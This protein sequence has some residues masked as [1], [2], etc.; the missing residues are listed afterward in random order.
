MINSDVEK[1]RIG[2]FFEILEVMSP[3][4][5]DSTLQIAQELDIPIGRATVLRG[6]LTDD[7]V[8]HI[9][10]LHCLVRDGSIAVE[11]AKDAYRIARRKEVTVREAL[12]ALGFDLGMS[13]TAMLGDLLSESDVVDQNAV[14]DAL[15][16]QSLCGMPIG[17]ILYVDSRVPPYIMFLALELQREIRRSRRSVKS[18]VDILR[19][20]AERAKNGQARLNSQKRNGS[21]IEIGEMLVESGVCSESEFS[22]VKGFAKVN[23]LEL[24]DAIRYTGMVRS[25]LMSAASALSGLVRFDY[26][27]EKAARSIFASLSKNSDEHPSRMRDVSLYQFLIMSGFLTAGDLRILTRELVSHPQEVERLAGVSARSLKNRENVRTAIRTCLM[28]GEKLEGLLNSL[29][30]EQR[31]LVA[32]ARDLVSLICL[33]R[34]DLDRAVLSFARMR[35]EVQSED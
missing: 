11:D 28:D 23:G 35:K 12:S 5:L 16:L 29:E 27:D 13:E 17:R 8:T 19:A 26:L 24:G 7:D 31:N 18:A 32:Y 9:V 15:A 33:G 3:E 10:Q 34:V 14:D 25:D 2:E 6:F 4:S 1:I 21:G 20:F 30:P 22:I